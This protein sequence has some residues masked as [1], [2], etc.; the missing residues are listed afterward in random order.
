[1]AFVAIMI[2][3]Q[4]GRGTVVTCL[5]R[6]DDM[7][8]VDELSVCV[9]MA[10]LPPQ[11]GLASNHILPLRFVISPKGQSLYVA[12]RATSKWHVLQS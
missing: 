10:L 9:W 8:V 2:G 5:M 3:S 7:L 12:F 6:L 11:K 4:E 1:M